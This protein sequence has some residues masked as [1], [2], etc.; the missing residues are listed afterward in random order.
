MRTDLRNVSLEILNLF[1]NSTNVLSEILDLLLKRILQTTY[2]A[3]E[4]NDLSE[5]RFVVG[6]ID[7]EDVDAFKPFFDHWGADAPSSRPLG[8]YRF[9]TFHDGNLKVRITYRLIEFIFF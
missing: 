5:N 7:F 4:A 2:R 9:L 8:R 3:L 6:Q 1:L